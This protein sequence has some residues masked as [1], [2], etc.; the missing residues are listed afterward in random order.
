MTPGLAGSLRRVV[1]LALGTPN[2]E[3]PD[4]SDSSNCGGFNAPQTQT[5][6][7][8][9]TAI[10]PVGTDDYELAAIDNSGGEQITLLPIPV[11]QLSTEPGSNKYNT[12]NPGTMFPTFSCAPY[13]DFNESRKPG[14]RRVPTDLFR[15]VGLRAIP[16]HG[17]HS[18]Q[19][20]H[21]FSGNRRSRI[22]EG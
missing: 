20:P 19:F 7:A 10:F 4:N 1:T 22:L 9:A 11:L 17:D 2:A 3:N 15:G 21:R 8:G 5:L 14:M 16:V 6:T 13:G 12:F 18:L